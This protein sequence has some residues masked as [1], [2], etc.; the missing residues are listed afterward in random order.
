[1]ELKTNMRDCLNDEPGTLYADWTDGEYRCRVQR[2]PCSINAYIGIKEGHPLYGVNYSDITLDCH[3]GLTFSMMGDDKYYPEGYWWIGWDYA[4][5]GDVPFY[6]IRDGRVGYEDREWSPA[7][8]KM[9]ADWVVF[10]LEK[11]TKLLRMVKQ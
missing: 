2:G 6:D 7:G 11:L 1:M 10:E 3:G 9:E 5:L 8:V 4:H